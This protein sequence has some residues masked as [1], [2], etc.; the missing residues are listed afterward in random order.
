MRGRVVP[1]SAGNPRSSFRE[2][3][4]VLDMIFVCP[5][6]DCTHRPARRSSSWRTARM[7][8]TCGTSFGTCT[9]SAPWK[10]TGRPPVVLVVTGTNIS[11]R[12]AARCDRCLVTP[13]RKR[14]VHEGFR[15]TDFTFARH[16]LRLNRRWGQVWVPKIGWVRFRWT[17]AVQDCK[18]Y[19]ITR[20][21]AGRWHVAF[22]VVPKPVPA[23]GTGEAVG[24]DRGVVITAALS[25]GERLHCPDLSIRERSRLRKAERRKARARK[26]SVEQQAERARIA[27]LRVREADRRKDWCEKISTDLAR[28]FDVIRFE[29]LRIKDMVRSAKGTA[30]NPGR[31]VRAKSGLNRAILAQGWGLLVRRTEDKAPGR[32]ERVLA[33]YTSL[34][35]SACGHVSRDSRDSQAGFCCTACGFTCN[36]DINASI[37]IAAGHAGG[38]PQSVRELQ[39]LVSLEGRDTVGIPPGEREDVKAHAYHASLRSH[40][41][42]EPGRDQPS[43]RTSARAPGSCSG[44]CASSRCI[45][46]APT[47]RARG[48]CRTGRNRPTPPAAG[49]GGSR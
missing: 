27:R 16:V 9:S 10:R 22:A 41:S 44:R 28:R 32:V 2:M 43:P 39:L 35:C 7:P 20:D 48:R 37:N 19:R 24:V 23:P 11:A 3:S 15:I 13:R 38:T 42:R 25:T 8:G 17:R 26:G 30:G 46:P 33:A 12:S 49:R 34:R 45:R 4:V 29:D 47:A 36:A 5:G 14:D 18:S 21:R 31:N 1:P 6:T 40:R